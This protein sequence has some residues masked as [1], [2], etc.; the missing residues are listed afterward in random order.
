MS[1]HRNCPYC[2]ENEFD[3]Y[4]LKLHLLNHPCEQFIAVSESRYEW[5]GPDSVC[6][7]KVKP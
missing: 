6:H 1:I 7:E 2:G 3:A 5:L 4:G